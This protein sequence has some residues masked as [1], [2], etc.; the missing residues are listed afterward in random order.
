MDVVVKRFV[1][2]VEE[3]L[4]TKG[5]W[6]PEEGRLRAA[7]LALHLFSVENYSTESAAVEDTVA[8]IAGK[9]RD[10]T[11]KL[12][13]RRGKLTVDYLDGT[14]IE[15]A[16]VDSLDDILEKA[17]EAIAAAMDPQEN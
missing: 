6:M 14:D 1:N 3:E 10:F 13:F 9:M 12:S 7:K 2:M 11:M 5:M 16:E 8:H 4:S 17:G 15:V